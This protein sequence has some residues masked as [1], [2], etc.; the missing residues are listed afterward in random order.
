IGPFGILGVAAEDDAVKT[1]N[2][3]YD[4]EAPKYTPDIALLVNADTD[5]VIYSKNADKV[6]APAS[7]VKIVTAMVA[8][9]KTSDL[10][11]KITCS[12]KAIESLNGT[13]STIMGLKA[14]EI[15]TLEMLLYG[16]FLPSANDAAAVIADHFGKGDQQKFIDEMNEYVKSLG[17][18]NTHFANA[19]G[20]DAKSVKGFDNDKQNQTTAYDMYLISKA[21]LANDNIVKISS[22]YGKTM[23]KTNKYDDVRY[24]Y[25]TNPLV[26]NYSYYFYDGAIGLKTGAT[27]KAGSCL[28]TSAT[29]DGYTYIAIAMG[30]KTNYPLDGENR[31]TSYLMCRYLLKWAF[32]NIRMRIVADTSYNIGEIKVKYGQGS[33]YV[34]LVPQKDISTIIHK[35][36]DIEDM[37][38][39]YAEDFPTE[40]KAP[41]KQ[42]DVVGDAKLM[43]NDVEIAE[44]T[45]VAQQSVKKN[46]LWA[47]FSWLEKLMESKL[48]VAF[49]ILAVVGAIAYFVLTKKNRQR[50]KRRKNSIE[51]IKDYSK[52]K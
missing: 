34:A 51:I 33:D 30:G 46:Y 28:V 14:G 35:Q 43:Y 24:L 31:N 38:V 5:T 6:T 40:I 44:I 4:I 26:N 8:L 22:K 39:E 7:L 29:K 37:T 12:E 11:T 10:N 16:M 9:N 36:I 19:H 45:L 42:G 17:C 18:K 25:N 47:M 32:S 48:F 13:Y 27:D 15:T 41:V 49:L 1:I 3:N 2:G 21:A 20:L 50:K 23:P 52:L